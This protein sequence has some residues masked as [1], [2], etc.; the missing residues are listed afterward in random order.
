MREGIVRHVSNYY[1][2]H[3]NIPKQILVHHYSMDD[4]HSIGLFNKDHFMS[5]IRLAITLAL[6]FN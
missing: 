3:N 6:G 5:Q 2:N 4:S 1:Q